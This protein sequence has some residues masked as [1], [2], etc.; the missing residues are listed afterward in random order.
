MIDRLKVTYNRTATIQQELMT[1][2]NAVKQTT[3][4]LYDIMFMYSKYLLTYPA[5]VNQRIAALTLL[6]TQALEYLQ[7][8]QL[9]MTTKISPRLIPVETVNDI[10]Q[11]ITARLSE[12]RSTFFITNANAVQF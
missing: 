12:E 3:T 4:D 1:L 11:T 10:F 6:Q 5:L 7:D 9:L 2:S 8:I